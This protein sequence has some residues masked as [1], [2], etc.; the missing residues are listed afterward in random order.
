MTE[1]KQDRCGSRSVTLPMLS[2]G[3]GLGLAA[4]R[5]NAANYYLDVNGAIAGSGVAAGGTYDWDNAIWTTDSTGTS[6]TINYA[7]GNFPRFAAATDL[8]GSFTLT[9]N[10]DHTCVG[11]FLED[12]PTNTVMT[13]N[14]TGAMSID[15]GASGHDQQGFL[16]NTGKSLKISNK[17]TGPGGI[18]WGGGGGSLFLY[19]NND[20]AGGTV[21]ATGN[22]LNINNDH[23]LSTGPITWSTGAA[24]L[25][26]PEATAPITIANTVNGRTTVPA[27]AS[28]FIFTG[29]QPITFSGPFNVAAGV[30]QTIQVGNGA[31]PSAQMTISGVLNGAGSPLTKIG[32]GTLILSNGSNSYGNQL[33]SD[34]KVTAGKLV[35]AN[36]TAIPSTSLVVDNT[37]AP[38]VPATAQYQPGLSTAVQMF[39]ITAGTTAGPNKG[40]VDLTDNSLVVNTFNNT[41]GSMTAAQVQALLASGYNAGAWNG[42]GINSSTAA[43]DP[44]HATSVGFADNT[45]LHQTSFKG[46]T[47]DAAGVNANDILVKYTYAGDANLDGKVDIGDLGLLA[48]AWQQSGKVWF[49]GDFTYDGNVDIGDLGLLAGNWQKGVGSGQL[50]VSFDQAMAQFAAF[51][52]VVVPEPASLS[53]LAALGGLALGRRRHRQR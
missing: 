2:L 45:V 21:F 42:P 1:K 35:I 12:G 5:A 8:A 49:D 11:M 23:S 43:A 18:S 14:G 22:G 36:V 6:N 3:I 20:Y 52:G 34:T 37:A 15:G 50:L 4:S 31:F 16:V 19:G 27:A 28:S 44:N 46:L 24:V 48:G 38:T 30:V 17:I 13:M 51:D 26:D 32:T 10:T 41:P 40:V 7:D 25:A 53:I 39:T 29:A 47:L 9:M 33:S